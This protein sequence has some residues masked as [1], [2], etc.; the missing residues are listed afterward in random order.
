MMMKNRNKLKKNRY[1]DLIFK[2]RSTDT[3]EQK[4]NFVETTIEHMMRYYNRDT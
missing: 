3:Y 1:D 2:L 4:N